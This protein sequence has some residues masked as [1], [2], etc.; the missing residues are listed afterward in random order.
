MFSCV[1]LN[2]DILQLTG[3]IATARRD[4]DSRLQSDR[5]SDCIGG[6]VYNKK[7]RFLKGYKYQHRPCQERRL[8]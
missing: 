4:C 5:E 8:S 2:S 3:D 6:R 7:Y 1:S